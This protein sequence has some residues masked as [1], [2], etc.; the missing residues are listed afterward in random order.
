[1]KISVSGETI[2]VE[3]V[4]SINELLAKIGIESTKNGIAVARNGSIVPKA[5]WEREAVNS[6]DVF[7]IVRASQGG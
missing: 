1:M 6:G 2:E 5:R 4:S 7:E 3:N